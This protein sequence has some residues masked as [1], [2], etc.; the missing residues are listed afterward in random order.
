MSD[1]L[2]SYWFELAE[3]SYTGQLYTILKSK[4]ESIRYQPVSRSSYYV[5]YKLCGNIPDGLLL[6]W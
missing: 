4:G 1:N 3:P 6:K 2:K 5:K